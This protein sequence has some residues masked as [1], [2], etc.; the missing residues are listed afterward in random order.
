MSSRPSSIMNASDSDHEQQQSSGIV[1]ANTSISANDPAAPERELE[2]VKAGRKHNFG[3]YEDEDGGEDGDGHTE[4]IGSDDEPVNEGSTVTTALG[5]A[6]SRSSQSM[7]P[8]KRH[9]PDSDGHDSSEQLP[10][11][12]IPQASNSDIRALHT[13]HSSGT[14]S[15]S[16]LSLLTSSSSSAHALRSNSAWASN[17]RSRWIVADRPVKALDLESTRAV[18]SAV[19]LAVAEDSVRDHLGFASNPQNP[20]QRNRTPLR[21]R[22]LEAYDLSQK[23][24]GG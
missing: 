15:P 3:E 9:H 1:L 11:V 22:K 10:S 16:I 6:N 7:P 2:A 21:S 12:H 24:T 4:T 19:D 23:R 20:H 14:S 18:G 17:N 5:C 8:Y 13:Q